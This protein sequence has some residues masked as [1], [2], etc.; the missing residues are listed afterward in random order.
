M[1]WLD[2]F[3]TL[4]E[5]MIHL[6]LSFSFFKRAGVHVPWTCDHGPRWV[7]GGLAKFIECGFVEK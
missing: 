3:T 5:E 6:S 4:Q 7:D 2:A 1:S